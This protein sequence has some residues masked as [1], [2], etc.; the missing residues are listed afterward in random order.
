MNK[1]VLSTNCGVAS[2]KLLQSW[3][4]PT[5][6]TNYIDC[7][8]PHKFPSGVGARGV[9]VWGE[10][11]PHATAKPF[12]AQPLIM[13]VPLKPPVCDLRIATSMTSAVALGKL[14]VSLTSKYKFHNCEST[15][16]SRPVP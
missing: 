10:G 11:K 9:C 12:Q 1:V 13:M 14:Q 6:I 2:H 7:W 4:G 5:D 8:A 3:P 16:G 15:H